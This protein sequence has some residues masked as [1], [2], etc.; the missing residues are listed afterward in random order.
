M[1]RKKKPLIIKCLVNPWKHVDATNENE[2]RK[3]MFFADKIC[4][5]EGKIVYVPRP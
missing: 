2:A 1:Y 4:M 3:K 5:T